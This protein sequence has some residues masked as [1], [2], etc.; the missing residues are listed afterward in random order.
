MFIIRL[1]LKIVVLPVALLLS[2]LTYI[3]TVLACLA[4]YVVGPFSMLM[5]FLILY[6]IAGQRW[7]DVFILGAAEGICLLM[8]AAAVFGI[9][10][11]QSLSLKLNGFVF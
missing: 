1:L 6:C 7:N 2:A 10:V 3:L 9:G 5:A 11:V 4:A 8:Y